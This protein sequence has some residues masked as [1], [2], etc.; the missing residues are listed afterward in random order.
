VTT[1]IGQVP[2]QLDTI[3]VTGRRTRNI[4]A[5]L[6]YRANAWVD[7]VTAHVNDRVQIHLRLDAP[8]VAA[9]GIQAFTAVL[10]INPWGL[11][12][13]KVVTRTTPESLSWLTY[14]GDSTLI[15]K[16]SAQS[17]SSL[18][19][20]SILFE[21][22]F[23]GLVTGDSVNL[24]R[25]DSLVLTGPGEAVY[26]DRH[27]GLV[28]LQGHEIDRKDYLIPKSLLTKVS[29]DRLSNALTVRYLAADGTMPD[30]H[31]VDVTGRTWLLAELPPAVGTPGELTLSAVDLP[32][33]IFA[34]RLRS[35]HEV[36]VQPI[37]IAR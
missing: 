5:G 7:T 2:L 27:N 4:D 24:V 23:Q 1:D 12:P 31:V 36:S 28:R 19:T 30:L 17:A 18:A 33:G 8:I 32:P 26:P 10:R 11:Y 34:V 9:N 20:S 22:E 21:I 29:F 35:G 15:I 25:L 16:G 6:P 37:M 13:W 14:A 3:T